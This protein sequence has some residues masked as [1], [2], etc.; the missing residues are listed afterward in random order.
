MLICRLHKDP[1]PDVQSQHEKLLPFP[2]CNTQN[3]G[4]LKKLSRIVMIC[5]LLIFIAE[6][7]L[8]K[9][10]MWKWWKMIPERK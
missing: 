10:L 8:G 6:R 1:A 2:K 3:L 5:R 7:G 9:A 4:D